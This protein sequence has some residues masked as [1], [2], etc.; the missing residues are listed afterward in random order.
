MKFTSYNVNNHKIAVYNSEGKKNPIIFLHANSIGAASFYK[1]MM[2]KEGEEYMYISIDYPGHGASDF[3]LQPRETYT[4]DGLAE[5]MSKTIEMLDI[6]QCVLCGHSLGG[7]IALRLVSKFNNNKIKALTLT[8]TSPL[9][10]YADWSSSYKTDEIFNIFTQ[11]R[12]N[13]YDS[14]ALAQL[15]VKKGGL[16]EI[17]FV[18]N[19]KNTDPNFRFVLGESFKTDNTNDFEL[20]KK[21]KIPVAF[22]EGEKDRIID[23]EKIQNTEI[24]NILWRQKVHIISDAGHSPMWEKPSLFNYMIN[25]FADEVLNA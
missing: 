24:K 7:H 15:F 19:I 8:G 1:Q 17:V 12:V 14:S 4:I 20:I 6:E 10:N 5:I 9:K 2:S 25:Q 11:P 22:I 18:D 13:D 3:S 23:I 21:L 16:A